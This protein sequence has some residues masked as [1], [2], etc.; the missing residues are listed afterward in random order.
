MAGGRKFKPYPSDFLDRADEMTNRELGVHYH[1]GAPCINHWRKIGGIHAARRKRPLPDDFLAVAPTITVNAACARWSATHETVKRWLKDAGIARFEVSQCQMPADFPAV[2][3]EPSRELAE[4]FGVAIT[5]IHN[6]RAKLGVPHPP[7]R[8]Q[9]RAQAEPVVRKFTPRR[10]RPQPVTSVPMLGCT[11]T[12]MAAQY[13]RKRG[14]VPVVRLK[15][16]DPKA[17]PNLY[18]V[19]SRTMTSGDMIDLAEARGFDPLEWTRLAA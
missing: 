1:V 7:M 6:W 13:L 12:D 11:N 10:G 18:R 5:T 4:R 8:R 14:Y 16:I 17:D 9:P 2:A 3:S 19:G 15:V